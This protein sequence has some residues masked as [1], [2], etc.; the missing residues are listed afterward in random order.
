MITGISRTGS[1][2]TPV[3]A[4]V[5]TPAKRRVTTRSILRTTT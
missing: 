3:R 4:T 1:A 2:D 5:A